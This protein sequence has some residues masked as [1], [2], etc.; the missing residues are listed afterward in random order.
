M[1]SFCLA[2]LLML[3]GGCSIE[4]TETPTKGT[5]FVYLPDF[6]A[7]VMKDEVDEFLQLYHSNGAS[8][9]DTIVSAETA[10]YHFVHDTSRMAFLPRPL[11]MAEKELVKKISPDF[12]ELIVAYDG[13]AAVVQ[14]KNKITEM[15]TTEIQKVLMGAI[16]RWEQIS[17]SM[18]GSIHIYCRDSSDVSE[19]L[20]QRLLKNTGIPVKFNRTSSD[21][22]TLRSVEHDPLAIGFAA[23]GWT[24][25]TQIN[26]KI[27]NL[28]RTK[29]DRDTAFAVPTESIGNFFSPHP[30]NIFR[31]Y[32][33]LKRAIYMYTRGKLDL[34]AGFGTYV[35]TAEGQKLFLKHRLLPG[36]QRIRLKTEPTE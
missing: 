31:N 35:A 23:L 10:A 9:M 32:Y 11:T 26:V 36:T 13:I 4:Q 27:L 3:V 21:V 33:P 1:R 20:Q 5:L 24:D 12:T 19:Y 30:A 18:K 14:P 15:T 17:K 2:C 8:I 7:P 29:E 34:A 6:I 28:G 25:T 22:Q 16:T